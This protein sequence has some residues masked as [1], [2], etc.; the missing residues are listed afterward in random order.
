NG[1]LP[2][3]FSEE[4]LRR[5]ALMQDAMANAYDSEIARRTRAKKLAAAKTLLKERDEF[6]A[7][8]AKLVGDVLALFPD[9]YYKLVPVHSGK[10]LVPRGENAV[11]GAAIIQIPEDDSNEA[12]KWQIIRKPG[13]PTQVLLKNKL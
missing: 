9:S 4:E 8:Q 11:Q 6:L 5:M 3:N 2:P 12:T 1:E 7:G 13:D 10:V